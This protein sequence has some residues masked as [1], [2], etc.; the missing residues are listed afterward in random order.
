MGKQFG[1][2]TKSKKPHENTVKTT[3]FWTAGKQHPKAIPSLL[4]QKALDGPSKST[5][6]VDARVT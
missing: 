5:L 2:K 6:L 1:P 3:A 4:V